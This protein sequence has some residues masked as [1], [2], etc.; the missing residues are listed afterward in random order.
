MSGDSSPELKAE[1]G[2]VLLLDIVGYS[3]LLITQQGELLETLKRLIHETGPV[4][5]AKEEGSL[6]LLPTGDGMALV[7]R[8]DLEAPLECALQLGAALR[9][10]PE[11]PLRMGIHSGPIRE[12]LDVNERTNVTGAGIDVAQRVMD[13]GDAGHILVSK[14][15]ADDLAPYPRWHAQLHDL[16]EAEVK[17]GAHVHLFNLYSAEAG[18]P[19]LPSKLGKIARAPLPMAGSGWK[20]RATGLA[21]IILISLGGLIWWFGSQTRQPAS[22]IPATS[23]AADIP[24]KSIAVLPFDNLSADPEN[25]FFADGVQD[26]ILT[27]LAKIADL[28]VISRSSVMHYKRGVERNLRQIGEELNVAHLLEGNVQRAPNRIRVNAQ[29]INARNGA[30]LWAQTYDRDLSDI[31]AIQSEI[32]KAIAEQLHAKLSPTEKSAIELPPTGDINAFDLYTKA[33]NF[34]LI[35]F[36]GSSGIAVLEQA[37]DLLNQ[38]VARDPSFF[39]AYCQLSRTQMAIYLLF[40]HSSARLAEAEAALQAAVRLRPDAAETHLAQAYGLYSGYLDYDGAM[41]ELEKARQTLPNDPEVFSLA[42]YIQRRQGR[43]EESTRNLERAI[44]L[45]PRNI[46][47][48]QQTSG[49]YLMFRRYEDARSLLARILAFAPDDPTTRVQLA[50]TEFDARADTRPLHE[51]VESIRKADPAAVQTIAEYW[52]VCA[53]AERDGA[54]ATEALAATHE[55]PSIAMSLL[56]NLNFSHLFLEAVVAHMSG[57]ETKTQTTLLAARREQEAIVQAQPNFGPTLTVLGL[58]DAGLGRKEDALREGRRAVELLP[59]EKDAMAGPAQV[60]YLAMIA[61]W[62]GDKDLA[63]ELLARA[64]QLPS[65]VTYGELALLPF[66]D[67]LRGDPRFEKIVASLAPKDAKQ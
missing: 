29:L 25:A 46:L 54:A 6:V 19:E 11:L 34:Y 31:F 41:A 12:V 47:T 24:G 28:K 51:T 21:L 59:A 42:G 58:I 39:P 13:C 65:T 52:L 26:E 33:K 22:Q 64:V 36:G 8:N 66:W 56:E 4:Q 55:N 63:C 37:A 60:K 45:D 15:V 17:H 38:A 7:F 30:H 32:A 44:E 49:S 2:H 57:D 40:D 43:W 18:N 53:L 3:K 16:G 23:V 48:L 50:Y 14:R 27:N 67:P 10:H 61:A 9:Q 62:V 20:R 1:I 35:G 5:S